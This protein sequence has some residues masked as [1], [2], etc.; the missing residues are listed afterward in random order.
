VKDSARPAENLTAMASGESLDFHD[1]A[2]ERVQL[3]RCEAELAR[4]L[5]CAKR[6]AGAFPS[7]FATH[8]LRRLKREHGAVL[9]SLAE[10]SGLMLLVPLRR[11]L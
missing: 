7:G 8:E 10:L 2:L 6:R 1:L 9:D 5:E 3:E 11:A 4:D